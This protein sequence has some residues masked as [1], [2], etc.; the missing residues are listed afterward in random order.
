MKDKIWGLT[1]ILSVINEELV[2]HENCSFLDEKGGKSYLFSD[3]HNE[4]PAS[5]TALVTNKKFRNK[6]VF[7]KGSHWS[8]KC[9]LMADLSARKE[10]LRKELSERYFLCLEEGRLSRN[11][12]TIVIRTKRL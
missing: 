6:C 1:K 5:G 4:N 9:E 3:D 7:C 11:C 12:Q 10:F 8:N 2:A